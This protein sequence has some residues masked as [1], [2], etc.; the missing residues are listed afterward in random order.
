MTRTLYD[1][2]GMR[3]IASK[4]LFNIH[5]GVYISRESI[6]SLFYCCSTRQIKS[7]SDE[8]DYYDYFIVARNTR[9]QCTGPPAD[10]VLRQ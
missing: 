3:L 9:G 10:A 2:R 7:E 1:S 6:L 8:R 4:C 5:T